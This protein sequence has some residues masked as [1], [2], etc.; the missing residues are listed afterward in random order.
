[1]PGDGDTYISRTTNMVKEPSRGGSMIRSPCL[2]GLVGKKKDF[3]PKEEE[4]DFFYWHDFYG[5]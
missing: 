5:F 1:M 4:E 2:P 3:F